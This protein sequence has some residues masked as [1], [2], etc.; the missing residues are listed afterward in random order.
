MFGRTSVMPFAFP[1]S[2]ARPRRRSMPR[3]RIA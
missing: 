3:R 2:I 1:N